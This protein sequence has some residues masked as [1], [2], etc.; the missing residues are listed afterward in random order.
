MPV[1]DVLKEAILG[2]RRAAAFYDMAARNTHDTAVGGIFAM[3]AEEEKGHARLLAKQ[4]AAVARDGRFEA[5]ADGPAPAAVD[6]GIVTH[7]VRNGILAAGFEAA[8][9]DAAMALEARA[10]RLY[11]ERAEAAVDENEKK[12]YSWLAAWERGHL[13]LLARLDEDLRESVWQDS[14]F[15]PMD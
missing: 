9:I 1:L 13:Q 11:G 10:V 5:L 14:N 12:I 15:W 6:D 7:A 2:E 3:M 8:A 4:Y